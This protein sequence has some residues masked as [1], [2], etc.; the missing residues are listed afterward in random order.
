M[1]EYQEVTKQYARMCDSFNRYGYNH[2]SECPLNSVRTKANTCAYWAFITD[3]EMAEKI[4]MTW[5]TEHP[6]KT[7]N[8]KFKEIFGFPIS[9]KFPVSEYD[10]EWLNKE[11]KEPEKDD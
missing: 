6:V 9:Q 4:I 10:S 8:D 3:P 7:N 1:A 11:Y 5:A 2:C